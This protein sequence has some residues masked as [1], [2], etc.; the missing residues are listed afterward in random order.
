MDWIFFRNAKVRDFRLKKRI[1]AS[2]LLEQPRMILALLI[3]V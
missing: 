3:E 2:I 1:I